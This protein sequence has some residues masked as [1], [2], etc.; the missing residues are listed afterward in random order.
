MRYIQDSTRTLSGT[1]HRELWEADVVADAETDTGKVCDTVVKQE[2][3]GTFSGLTCIELV[4]G[5]SGT[6]RLAF[7]HARVSCVRS[8]T[9][10]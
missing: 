6:Q 5:I 8:I 7:L 4:D 10:S 3:F 1:G 2:Y 9:I